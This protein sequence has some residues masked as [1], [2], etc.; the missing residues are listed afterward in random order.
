MNL[1][2]KLIIGL[3]IIF[4]LS[5]CTNSSRSSP[6][7]IVPLSPVEDSS[8]NKQNLPPAPQPDL[9][10][11]KI[12]NDKNQEIQQA[13]NNE[14][15]IDQRCI[16]SLCGT[17]NAFSHPFDGNPELVGTSKA[18][19]EAQ[20][21][22]PIE[23]YMGRIIHKALI[24]DSLYKQLLDRK[25]PV[26]LSAE[27]LAFVQSMRYANQL[28]QS[29]KYA[30]AFKMDNEGHL[31]FDPDQLKM[32]LGNNQTDEIQAILSLSDFMNFSVSLTNSFQ[33]LSLEALLK[34]FYPESS[35]METQKLEAKSMQAMNAHL[36][37]IF[38][39][40]AYFQPED[41]VV[42]KA[43]A[44]ADFSY[45]EKNIFKSKMLQKNILV[46]LVQPK[47]QEAFAKLPLDYKIVM[48]EFQTK[49]QQS[50]IG[51]VVAHPQSLKKLLQDAVKT[52]SND[53]SYA[54]TALPS[55]AQLAKF[56][57]LSDE[58]QKMGQ[59]MI[60]E[61]IHA[62]LAEPPKIGLLLPEDR[63]KALASWSE[64]IL[65]AVQTS[66]AALKTLKGL[67]LNEPSTL[68]YVFLNA[69][70]LSDRDLFSDVLEFCDQAKIPFLDDAAMANLNMINL[71]WPTIVHPEMG[72]GILAHELGHIVSGQWPKAVE[73][74]K[75]C[76][77]Q[78]QG[79]DQ[80][81]EEDFADTFSSELMRRLNFKIE[82][83]RIRNFG[84]ALLPRAKDGAGWADATLKNEN[85][86]DVHSSSFYRLMAVA[87][88]TG[89]MSNQCVD[90]L[91]S[92]GENRFQNYCSWK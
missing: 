49:Y 67:S 76:L 35:M 70:L 23:N 5:A 68:E 27:K 7:K 28:L 8:T 62:S 80:H 25:D 90:Y 4:T 84:C 72:I 69:S 13:L 40:Y 30:K 58:I 51:Q 66:D 29:D 85:K 53:L 2:L 17:E 36:T 10:P 73:G 50:K 79:N 41:L 83:V 46:F 77:K 61:R 14:N 3:F 6:D 89:K 20:L 56:S 12:E 43:L 81:V 74:E 1:I 52:C 59:G 22:K 55:A 88:D 32:I 15:K 87:T 91:K 38:P 47:V 31:T 39:L 44:G 64:T 57:R 16:I 71:S 34:I 24:V 9:D 26:Q 92:T 42:K 19:I 63:D 18:F 33:R 86:Y 11:T 48:T 60:E 45:T 37:S 21:K 82:D 65:N 78:K 75:D 54:Y